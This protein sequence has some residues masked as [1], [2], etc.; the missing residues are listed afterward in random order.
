MLAVARQA[1][2]L[3]MEQF[4]LPWREEIVVTVEICSMQQLEFALLISTDLQLDQ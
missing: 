3:L 4:Q 1:P 2:L